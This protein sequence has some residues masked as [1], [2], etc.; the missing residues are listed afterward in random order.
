MPI[1]PPHPDLNTPSDGPTDGPVS[2]CRSATDDIEDRCY[3]ESQALVKLSVSDSQL[4]TAEPVWG[5][6]VSMPVRTPTI[7]KGF[8]DSGIPMAEKESAAAAK[9]MVYQYFS[10][11]GV[12]L[13]DFSASFIPCR[14]VDVSLFSFF[15]ISD[16]TTCTVHS[17]DIGGDFQKG[18]SAQQI[19]GRDPINKPITFKPSAN[20]SPYWESFFRSGNNVI[21]TELKRLCPESFQVAASVGGWTLS[22]HFT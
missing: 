14:H 2:P 9:P 15:Q 12:Y 20:G 19:T 1:I 4:G 3:R 7:P 17:S 18:S 13:R 22:N 21:F 6:R 16:T 5:S 11:W 8:D 10:A